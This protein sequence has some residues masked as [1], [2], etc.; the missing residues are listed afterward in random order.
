MGHMTKFRATARQTSLADKLAAISALPVGRGGIAS[1]D[2][3]DIRR[4]ASIVASGGVDCLP[5]TAEERIN[6]LYHSHFND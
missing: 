4:W 1:Y 3:C 5:D 2:S 6:T